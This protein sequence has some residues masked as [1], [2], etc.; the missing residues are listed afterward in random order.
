MTTITKNLATVFSVFICVFFFPFV[1]A[2]AAIVPDTCAAGRPCSFCELYS[3]AVSIINF[4]IK[5]AIPLAVLFIA[6]GGI[7]VLTASGPGSVSRGWDTIKNALI[8]IALVFGA[9]LIVNTFITFLVSGEF[10]LPWK[11]FSC[12]I[13]SN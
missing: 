3:L 4:L 5:L 7:Q 2:Q 6:W 10:N 13:S 11:E 12:S 1:F 8:G 9:W